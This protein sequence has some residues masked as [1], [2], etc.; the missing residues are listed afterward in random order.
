MEDGTMPL[1]YTIKKDDPDYAPGYKTEGLVKIK[2][3]TKS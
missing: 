3:D 1:S 2:F